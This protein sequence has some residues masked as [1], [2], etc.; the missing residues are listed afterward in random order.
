MNDV[1]VFFL[2][3]NNKNVCAPG[4]EGPP[5]P[6]GPQLFIKGD[7]GAPGIQG[8]PGPQGPAGFPGLKGQQGNMCH[9]YCFF[10]E[11]SFSR[12]PDILVPFLNYVMLF[13]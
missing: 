8:L 12:Y 10:P 13:P 2:M 9:I 11:T 7:V 4:G 1:N 3:L 6:P 5:G